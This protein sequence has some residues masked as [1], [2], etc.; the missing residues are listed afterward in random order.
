MAAKACTSGFCTPSII[1]PQVTH[2]NLRLLFAAL[3]SRI[4]WEDFFQMRTFLSDLYMKFYLFTYGLFDD[5]VS[6]LDHVGWSENDELESMWVMPNLRSSLGLWLE[7][8]GEKSSIRKVNLWVRSEPGIFQIRSTNNIHSTIILWRAAW[9]PEDWY[10]YREAMAPLN[11]F[12]LQLA[13][14]LLHNG[15]PELDRSQTLRRFRGNG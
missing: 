11:A 1:T 8:L 12:P 5:T 9:R 7:G 15:W 10:G 6:N 2:S 14:R 3:M 13:G 4:T